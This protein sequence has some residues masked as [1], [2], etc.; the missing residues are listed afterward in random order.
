MHN[1]SLYIYHCGYTIHARVGR[2]NVCNLA[3]KLQVTCNPSALFSEPE[4]V[5]EEVEVELEKEESPVAEEV[6]VS[7]APQFTEV[8]EDVVSS[9][10]ILSQ[11]NQEN[12]L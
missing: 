1:L 5:V 4:K 10:E 8:Y 7:Q 9:L 6:V 12:S 2:T 11:T 3:T